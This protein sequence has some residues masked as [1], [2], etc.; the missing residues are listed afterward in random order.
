NQISYSI[1]KDIH[2]KTSTGLP[3]RCPSPP[4]KSAAAPGPKGRGTTSLLM[5]GVVTT[6]LHRCK[7]SSGQLFS[8]RS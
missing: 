2:H 1:H 5:M 3:V 8:T 4:L 7:W 6:L